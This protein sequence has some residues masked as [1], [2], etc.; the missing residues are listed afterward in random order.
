M[1]KVISVKIS[2]EK[3][4]VRNKAF[5]PKLTIVIILRF[6]VSGGVF[7]ACWYHGRPFWQYLRVW[8]ICDVIY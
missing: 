7:V 2:N 1:L 6:C 3:P 5:A 4:V 8:W